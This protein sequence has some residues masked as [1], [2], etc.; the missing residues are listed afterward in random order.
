MKSTLRTFTAFAIGCVFATVLLA[1]CA[2][3][4]DQDTDLL[5]KVS[6]SMAQHEV[7]RQSRAVV[8]DTITKSRHN[9][10]TRSVAKVSPAVVGINVTA[11]REYYRPSPFANDPFF[12]HFFP[13][14]RIMREVESLGSGFIFSPEGHILTNY[15]VV[16]SAVEI[17]VTMAGGDQYEAEV[18]GDDFKTDIAVLKI[19]SDKE[20]PYID[21]GNSDDIIIG[22]WAIALGNPFG[23]FDVSAKPTV[24]VGVISATGQDFGRQ[25]GGRVY[26]DMIQTDAAINSGNSGGPLVNSQGKVIGINTFIVPASGSTGNIG[27]GFAI[28]I[29]RVKHHLD[30]LLKFGKV[31]RNFWTG[32]QY[33][34]LTPMVARYLGLES[35]DGVIITDIETN[36]PAE[37]AGLQ[38][39]DVILK[40]NGKKVVNSDDV[41]KII[42]SEDLKQ[43]DTLK[44][45][46]SR[47]GELYEAN[48][49][50]KPYPKNRKR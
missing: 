24:T 6:D 37:E 15:H 39:G 50:L 23:L 4:T 42:E 1:V 20:F 43:G 49:T 47:R 19:K 7:A 46:I 8:N 34:E 3:K 26:E 21:F 29:N 27:I 12:R 9:A 30:D 35:T 2:E 5:V 11:V 41:K 32:I 10:I 33:D 31:K 14:Y 18:I 25:S 13:N 16:E 36:S 28:P 22:E 48:V 40:I 17:I 38:Y 44:L 45:V